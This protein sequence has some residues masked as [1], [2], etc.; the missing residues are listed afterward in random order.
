MTARGTVV[1]KEA[2]SDRSLL[3][4]GGAADRNRERGK[5]CPLK[6]INNDR[7]DIGWNDQPLN[8]RGEPAP[9]MVSNAFRGITNET[10][11]SLRLFYFFSLDFFYRHRYRF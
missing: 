5:S 10:Q 9:N 3:L 2:T 6:N 11:L 1:S 4:T 7:F 8:E